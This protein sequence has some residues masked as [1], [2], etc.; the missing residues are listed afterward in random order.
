MKKVSV[1]DAVGSVLAYDI[2]E[3][4]KEKGT[5][6]R[7]YRRG[8]V[9]AA[10]DLD[11]LKSL[12]RKTVFIEDGTDSGVHEDDAAK[13]TAPLAAG[14]NITYDDEPTE[15]KI[16][17]YAG[18]RGLFKVD[19]ERLYK[20]NMLGVPSLPTIH[21]NMGVEQWKPVA[22]FRIIPL[23]CEQQ[24]MDSLKELLRT[25]LFHIKPYVVKTASLLVTGS[26]V[27]EG[28]IKDGFGPIIKAKLKKY[29]VAV[30]DY[31][32]V[33]DDLAIVRDAVREMAAKTD[34][35]ITTGGTSVD[36]DDITAQALY[37]AGVRYEMKGTPIQPGNNLTVGY[38]DG[39]PV[40]AVPAA[41]LHFNATS[42]DILLPRI[43]AGEKIGKAD[44]AKLAHGGLC[45]FCKKC[46]YPICPFGRG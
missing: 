28:R 1:E 42:L 17:F 6:G 43:L 3:V 26:E 13:I 30:T 22:A 34:M 21:N 14:E 29:N 7:A 12:G 37:D 32:I 15:G 35:V 18:C 25:P 46:V 19:E 10:S 31:R 5:K 45:H 27:F 2:T 38:L 40:C 9:I 24:I 41:A 36:P 44:L 33:T 39:K 11:H 4:N 23:V 20:I 16:S 8:H